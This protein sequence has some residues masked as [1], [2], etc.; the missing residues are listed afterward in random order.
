MKFIIYIDIFAFKCFYICIWT[1]VCNKEFIII[2]DTRWRQYEQCV[3]LPFMRNVSMVYN[4]SYNTSCVHRVCDMHHKFIG[5]LTLFLQ[6]LI[7]MRD[8]KT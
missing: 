8:I 6:E 5:Q 4:E 2:N 3:Y 7:Y 1:I